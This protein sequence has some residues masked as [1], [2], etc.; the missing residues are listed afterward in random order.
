[1]KKRMAEI[2]AKLL[3][4]KQWLSNDELDA[5]YSSNYWNDIEVEKKKEWWIADGDYVMCRNY[6]NRAGLLT[7]WA[8][9]EKYVKG[10]SS[11]S[12]LKVADLAAGIGWTSALFSTFDSIEEVH[13]TEI[14]RHRISELL[15]YAID[16]FD[17]QPEK[18][19][20]YIGSPMC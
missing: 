17:G 1:M 14:S 20:R 11:A 8:E 9:V 13:A 12:K 10:L 4:V 7:E 15:P 5:I 3:P 6:L 19:K 2:E 18:I 16:M